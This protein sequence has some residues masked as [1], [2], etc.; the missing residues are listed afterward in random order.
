MSVAGDIRPEQVRARAGTVV[1]AVAWA[2]GLPRDV[3]LKGSRKPV[4]ARARK[5]ACLLL[6]DLPSI[7][8]NVRSY[9]DVAAG[10]GL[11]C[12]TTAI[13]NVSSAREIMARDPD[14]AG[15]VAEAM[16]AVV[17]IEAGRW[18]APEIDLSLAL[19]PAAPVEAP[20][21]SWCDQCEGRVLPDAVSRCSWAR[22]GMK[23][24]DSRPPSRVA[25]H[26]KP[27]GGGAD[28][29]NVAARHAAGRG[30]V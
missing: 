2:F 8:G 25:G 1:K 18:V 4:F 7:S 6:R 17:E 27:C 13:Y 16:V 10:V 26:G 24:R 9:P 3:V 11:K 12:H 23:M 21:P 19:A 14:Y 29:A 22:C 28:R 15:K 30:G 5:A 20:Q